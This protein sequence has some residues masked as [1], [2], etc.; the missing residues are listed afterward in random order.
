VLGLP[1]LRTSF[2]WTPLGG[3]DDGETRFPNPMSWGAAIKSQR[4]KS[5][6]KM[7]FGQ[8]CVLWCLLISLARDQCSLLMDEVMTGKKRCGMW[9][10]DVEEQVRYYTEVVRIQAAQSRAA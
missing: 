3:E 9:A 1:S 10:V 5:K 2:L 8:F 7:Y 4:G 6:S